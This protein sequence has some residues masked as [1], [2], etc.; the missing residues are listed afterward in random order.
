[1]SYIADTSAQ[2]TQ[3]EKPRSLNKMIIFSFSTI[4]T[5]IVSYFFILPSVVNWTKGTSAVHKD[6]L[7]IAAVKQGLF[8]RDLSVQGKVIAA[9]RPILYSPAQGTVTYL[10]EAGDSVVTQQTIA[11]IDSPEL[12]SEYNQQIANLTRLKN[13]LER[14]K[15]QVKKSNLEQENQ[16]GQAQVA[17]NAAKREMRRSG[18]AMKNK[19][20]SDIDYQKAKDDLQNAKREYEHAVKEVALIK[21]SQKF[22]IKTREF[23]LHSQQVKVTELKRQVDGLKIT[24]PVTGL[25]G[26]LSTQQKNSVA[27]NQALLSIVDLSEYELEVQIPESYADDL[28]LGMEAEITLN[29][30]LYQG[31]LVA[32]SPEIVQGRVQ[33]KIRF[34]DK[35]L[36]GLRQN[37]RL[38]T[39][40]ILERKNNIQYLPRGQF[41]KTY[42]GQF[43]YVVSDNSAVKTPIKIGSRSLG[44]VEVISGLKTGDTVVISDSDIFKDAPSVRILK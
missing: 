24:S 28:A 37:Q 18:E 26:N 40:V 21:E 16:I 27:K 2:D 44:K 29:Q 39:R 43:A 17:L 12:K 38:T 13:Q 31:E 32:I 7:N 41:L 11:I 22:E 8:I 25:V 30:S 6:K 1:M 19:I 36:T 9:R 42:N 4:L 15:I 33:G 20:I 35:S 34:T 3:I 14:E 10:V 5:V 23:E